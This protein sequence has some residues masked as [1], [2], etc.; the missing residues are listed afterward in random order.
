MTEI[1]ALA[2]E[3]IE[4][5]LFFLENN[6]KSLA[7]SRASGWLANNLGKLNN[8]IY[9]NFSGDN[10]GLKYEESSIYKNIYMVNY[11]KGKANSVLKNMDQANLEWIFL[12]EGDSQIQ[13]QNKNEV[14]KTYIQLSKEKELETKDLIT[15]YN[16]YESYPRQ[17]IIDY[18][19][20]SDTQNNSYEDKYE[21]MG[22]IEIQQGSKEVFI[23]LNLTKTPERISISLVKPNNDSIYPNFSYSIIGKSISPTGF[24][25]SLG[26]TVNYS[27]YKINYGVK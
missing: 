1:G 10:P 15:A 5:E 7:I 13:L 11:Y 26:A 3:I 17:I 16:L 27:G 12:K 25:A 2:Q 20:S 22:N 19:E 4:D 21:A 23:P 24:V 18:G 6:E 14:A 8:R 9:T